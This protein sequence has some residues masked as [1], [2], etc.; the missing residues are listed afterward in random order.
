MKVAVIHPLKH[1]VYYSLEGVAQSGTKVVGLF[2]YYNRGDFID[3]LLCKTKFKS[4]VDGWQ[5]EPID[6]YVKTSYRIKL[7]FLLSKKWPG[8]FKNIYMKEFQKWCIMQLKDMDC[9][10]VLQDYCN[11]VIQYA[12]GRGMKIVYEQII[13]FDAEQFITE[14]SD[15]NNTPKLKAEKENLCIADQ[16]I[17]ASDFVKQSILN[18]LNEEDIANKMRIIPY[19]ADVTG[20]EFRERIYTQGDVL[21]LITVASVSRRK[22]INFLIEAMKQLQGMPVHLS[23][24]GLPTEDGKKMLEDIKNIPNISYI[25]SVP[26]S[27]IG[28]YYDKNDV[29]ILPS[30]AEGSSLSVYEA[31]ASGLPCIVTRNVGSVIKDGREGIIIDTK[32]IQNIITSIVYL[33]ENPERVREM[34]R[35]TQMTI[36]KYEWSA[37]TTKMCRFYHELSSSK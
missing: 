18:H 13:A 22:G 3:K 9:I 12:H 26:H 10:H 35:E 14:K 15:V 36:L 1:H 4:L 11:D 30:L 33:L 20:Y 19:G 2:G 21:R 7:L 29:F 27:K 8:K 37:Y 16:I 17:M 6:K 25:G 28:D 24:I 32:N 34:S 23:L 5:Y 31:L